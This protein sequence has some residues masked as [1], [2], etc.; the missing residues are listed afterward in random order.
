MRIG[1]GCW[2][3]RERT[4]FGRNVCTVCR[5]EQAILPA[6][7]VDPQVYGPSFPPP[8]QPNPYPTPSPQVNTREDMLMKY[9]DTM[10]RG[11][12]ALKCLPKTITKV[13]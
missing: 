6:Q 7:A 2:S 4:A 9:F 11:S 5:D 10:T 1:L 8:L 12:A 13:K 3:S